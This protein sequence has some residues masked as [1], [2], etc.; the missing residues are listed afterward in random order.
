MNLK[1][2][3]AFQEVMAT[4]SVSQAAR[5]LHRTQPSISAAIASLEEDLGMPLF[6]RRGGRLHPVP[7]ARYLTE[8]CGELLERV[9]A[10]SRNM[11]Q[12]RR[13]ETGAIS[14]AS[15]PGPSVAF[16]PDLLSRRLG[17][18][19]EVRVT[20]QSRS[21]AAVVELLRTQQYD[22]GIAD[23]HDVPAEE[24]GLI[25]TERV[26]LA[27][28]CALPAGHRLAGRDH[29]TPA[30]L[31][32]ERMGTL[33]RGHPLVDRIEDAFR[34]AGC[35]YR[36]T[37]VTQ[38]F[39]PLLSFVAGGQACAVVDP[40]TARGH[41]LGAAGGQVAFVPFRP[42]IP[43]EVAVIHPAHRPMSQLVRHF[44]EELLATLR[45]MAGDRP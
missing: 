25:R 45:G 32:G 28:L 37:I 22:L 26:A 6:E 17:P 7:E 36:G 38:Y 1:Q 2:M 12:L 13:I 18:A 34:E 4:G 43:F 3:R 33:L 29:V 15:M 8:E 30:D 40:I 11:R 19:G 24:G 23:G 10:I 35:V 20:L 9:E 42:V 31:D 27:C 16:L 14:I 21:S 41:A 44:R 5:N 39:V